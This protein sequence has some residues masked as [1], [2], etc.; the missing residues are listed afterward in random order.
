MYFTLQAALSYSAQYIFRSRFLVQTQDDLQDYENVLGQACQC[1]Q[2]LVITSSAAS[3]S[4]QIVLRLREMLRQATT[5]QGSSSGAKRITTYNELVPNHAIE[6]DH[7]H[8]LSFQM[9][10]GFQDGVFQTSPSNAGS[11]QPFD[12]H[13]IADLVLNEWNLAADPALFEALSNFGHPFHVTG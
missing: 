2:G 11:Y 8:E 12:N 6:A 3:R 7:R 10:Q 9:A 5:L 13:G 4:L 1:L